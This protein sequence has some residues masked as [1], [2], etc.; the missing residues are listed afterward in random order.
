M[1]FSPYFDLAGKINS[2]KGHYDTDYGRISV[3]WQRTG[4]Y[5]EY[6]VSAPSNVEC[7]FVFEGMSVSH[8]KSANGE[9]CFQLT[10]SK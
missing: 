2:V 6:R 3:E 8:S 9:Y 1:K 4:D 7:E 5:Y 10:V